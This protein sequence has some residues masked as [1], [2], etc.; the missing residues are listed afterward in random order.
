M[1]NYLISHLVLY[2]QCPTT[3]PALFALCFY[4]RSYKN[5]YENDS[6]YSYHAL[7]RCPYSQFRSSPACHG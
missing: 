1:H 5:L 3:T 7:R 4:Y 6:P 2:G